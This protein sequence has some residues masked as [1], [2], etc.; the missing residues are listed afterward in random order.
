MR[1]IALLLLAGCAGADAMTQPPVPAAKP[2]TAISE[3]GLNPGENMAF[4]IRIAGILAGEAQLAVGDLGDYEGHRAV[5]VK[6]RAATV[7]AVAL[8]KH[9]VD[10]AA[11]VIDMDS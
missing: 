4:E 8:V 1:C 2:S 7:G 9:V 11:T 5:V 3:I 10:E 6:S